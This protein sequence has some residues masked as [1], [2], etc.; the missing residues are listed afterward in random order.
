LK[1][2]GPDIPEKLFMPKFKI[3]VED[4][5]RYLIQDIGMHG[6][7]AYGFSEGK[8]W[9]DPAGFPPEKWNPSIEDR[10]LIDFWIDIE[11]FL[12]DWTIKGHDLRKLN[13]VS[14]ENNNYH[15][16]RLITSKKDTLYYYF[17]TKTYLLSMLSFGG[18]ISTGKEFPTFTFQK[19]QS[20]EGIKFSFKRINL[21]RTLDGTYGE[22]EMIITKII[23]N[24][25]F[26]KNIFTLNHRISNQKKSK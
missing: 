21:F 10:L 1:K 20:I 6:E 3:S 19:Y 18:D 13:S 16:I 4:K 7:G 5:K 22:S 11:G 26:N 8:Y 9:K 2:I 24:P 25:K 23:I 15:R 12:V 14:I 17:N